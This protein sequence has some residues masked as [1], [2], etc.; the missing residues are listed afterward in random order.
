ML[1]NDVG[2]NVSPNS[3]D[4]YPS[5]GRE[6]TYITDKSALTD[7]IGDFENGT[8][9]TISPQQASQLE[10]SLGLQEGAISDGFKIRQVD[11][12][13]DRNPRSPYE[14]TNSNFQ[15]AGEHLPGGGPEAVIDSIPTADTNT[16][17]M[18]LEITVGD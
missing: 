10:R 3:W 14:G 1:E 5:L 2:Y 4:A 7:V 18:I 6:G 11:N 15:G 13:T 16:S 9:V 17:R 8:K 12:V